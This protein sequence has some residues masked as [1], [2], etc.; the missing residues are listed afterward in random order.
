MPKVVPA[1]ETKRIKE[2]DT[3]ILKVIWVIQCVLRV[4][5]AELYMELIQREFRFSAKLRHLNSL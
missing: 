5:I 1:D 3:K 2:K 4:C